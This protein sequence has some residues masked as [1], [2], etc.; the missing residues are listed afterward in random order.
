MLPHHHL[1]LLPNNG[2][3]DIIRPLPWSG[4]EVVITALTRNQVTG[5]RPWVRIPPAPLAGTLDFPTFLGSFFAFYPYFSPY[6]KQ[7]TRPKWF[8]YNTRL[9]IIDT[10]IVTFLLKLTASHS[11]IFTFFCQKPGRKDVF[12]SPV[13]YFDHKSILNRTLSFFGLSGIWSDPGSLGQRES[14]PDL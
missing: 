7:K 6:W 8:Y 4:I 10:L 3:Y 2:R 9:Y 5:N 14:L 1:C 11:L 12:F 13:Q